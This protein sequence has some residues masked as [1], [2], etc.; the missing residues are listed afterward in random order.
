MSERGGWVGW[1]GW[2]GGW[3]GGCVRAW[4]GGWVG[5]CVCA[6]VCLHFW[7]H[8]FWGVFTDHLTCR[9]QLQQS[10]PQ[11]TCSPNEKRTRRARR[12]RRRNKKRMR[13]KK[14]RKK[15]GNKPQKV[16]KEQ[17]AAGEEAESEKYERKQR[18]L[19]YLYFG[20]TALALSKTTTGYVYPYLGSSPPQPGSFY[21][22][23]KDH[24]TV[25]EEHQI[26]AGQTGNHKELV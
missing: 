20:I 18:Q 9:R 19:A 1:V 4:V 23:F 5:G 8:P 24:P 15:K 7:G 22:P 10:Q 17:G 6:C 16:T 25:P 2:V 26:T 14:K 21:A 3:V 12:G 11:P 13:K